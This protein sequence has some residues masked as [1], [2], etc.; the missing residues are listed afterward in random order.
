M[1]PTRRRTG[2]KTRQRRRGVTFEIVLTTFMKK[3]RGNKPGRRCEGTW[4]E[5]SVRA[6][7]CMYLCWSR[8]MSL[9]LSFL[10]VHGTWRMR[11]SSFFFCWFQEHHVKVKLQRTIPEYFFG[12]QSHILVGR[13]SPSAKMSKVSRFLCQSI[14]LNIVNR[15]SS[16]SV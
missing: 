12:I 1:T 15:G 8:R 13:L 14:F 9:S 6:C 16:V 11:T 3:E 2:G 5:G 10:L 7:L 4:V